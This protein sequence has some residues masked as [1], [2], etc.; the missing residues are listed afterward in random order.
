MPG[1]RAGVAGRRRR[2]GSGGRGRTRM[3]VQA[4]NPPRDRP[5]GTMASRKK[6]RGGRG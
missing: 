2:G 1:R 3:D 6:K 5:S 4:T